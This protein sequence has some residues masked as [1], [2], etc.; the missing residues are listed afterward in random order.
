MIIIKPDYLDWLIVRQSLALTLVTG[1]PVRIE[2]AYAVVRENPSLLLILND[3]E[4]IFR[5]LK[6][7]TLSESDNDLIFEPNSIDYGHYEIKSAVNSSVPEILMVLLPSLLTKKFRSSVH[8][9]GVT[10]SHESYPVNFINDT[11]FSFLEGLGFYAHC[12]LKHFGFYGSGNGIVESKIYPFTG[13]PDIDYNL[14]DYI[15][16]DISGIRAC[17]Y[18]AKMNKEAAEKEKELLVSGL[19]IPESDISIIEIINSKGPGNVVQVF[20]QM[21]TYTIIFS[22][23]FDL[24]SYQTVQVSPDEVISSNVDS[25][26]REFHEFSSAR[27]CPALLEREIIPLMKLAGVDYINCSIDKKHKKIFDATQGIADILLNGFVVE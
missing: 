1:V 5:E 16:Q 6:L 15:N 23:I 19:K 27:S 12:S 11:I 24:S 3:F 10:H 2:N 25:L 9:N 8:V 21:E 26:C 20:Q 13:A 4:K 7:G 22:R 18:V 17:V 14:K